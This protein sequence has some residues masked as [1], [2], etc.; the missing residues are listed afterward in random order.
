MNIKSLDNWSV[1]EN[2]TLIR[3]PYMLMVYTQSSTFYN[4]ITGGF[5][6]EIIGSDHLFKNINEIERKIE[7]QEDFIVNEY[8]FYLVE[9]DAL[10]VAK[11]KEA[12]LE[13]CK[14]YGPIKDIY[15]LS[16]EDFLTI[17]LEQNLASDFVHQERDIFNEEGEDECG[18]YYKYYLE[19]VKHAT[20]ANK[21]CYPIIH[22]NL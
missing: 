16:E 20:K 17:V 11:N 14:S 2:G 3:G 12:V 13:F 18:S 1:K 22:F 6:K 4:S 19:G 7:S 10:Y 21:D 9:D 8:R 5:S 15:D